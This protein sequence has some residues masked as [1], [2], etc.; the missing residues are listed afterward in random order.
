MTQLAQVEASMQDRA[1]SRESRERLAADAAELRRQLAQ[2]SIDANAAL[3]D[4]MVNR[5]NSAANLSD[6][7]ADSTGTTPKKP[8]QRF[9]YEGYNGLV[10][11][12]HQM[13]SWLQEFEKNKHLY[14]KGPLSNARASMGSMLGGVADENTRKLTELERN[15]QR[16]DDLPQRH[17]LFGATLSSGEKSSWA[18][19]S[20]NPGMS[21][22]DIEA[23]MR[24]RLSKAKRALKA[25]P[26]EWEAS[27]ETSG[28]DEYRKT[29]G[30]ELDEDPPTKAPGVPAKP[31]T[32]LSGAKVIKVK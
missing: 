2:M 3:K 5:N 23:F 25:L 6:V 28:L 14:G 15:R 21:P 18:G 1:A 26:K 27:H 7:K 19:A 31:S 13:E 16:F 22:K 32:P 11:E 8:L 9:Q 17:K 20:I 10:D 12:V 30:V 4:S 24:E 29:I